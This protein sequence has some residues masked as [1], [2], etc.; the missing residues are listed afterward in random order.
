MT[1][2]RTVQKEGAARLSEAGIE[3]ADR[4]AAWLLEYVTGRP[5]LD[6]LLHDA[7][8]ADPV[9]VKRF[10]ALVERRV[11]GEPLQYVMGSA[12]FYGRLFTVGPGVLIP[13]PETE[14]LVELALARAPGH[15][16]ILD[17]CTGSGIIPIT[18]ALELPQRC[19]IVGVDISLT[20]LS[21]AHRN[22][23]EHGAPVAWVAGDLA[24]PLRRDAQFTMITANPPYISPPEYE[25]L[26]PEV[27]DHEPKL[28]LH[29]DANGLALIDRIAAAARRLLA[30]GGSVLCEIGSEQGPAAAECFIAHGFGDVQIEPDLTRRDRFIW[31]Q[32]HP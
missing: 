1:T 27:R 3:Q 18:L 26:S 22:G 28:A 19:G 14:H 11:A 6:F 7:A 4:E 20:A 24:E 2:L 8:T 21:Y 17:L 31:A 30:P 29:A 5:G 15:G 23:R 10:L 13:R 12:E 16:A 32:Q 9:V 25:A